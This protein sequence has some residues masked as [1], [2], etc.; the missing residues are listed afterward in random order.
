HRLSADPIER[1]DMPTLGVVDD[2]AQIFEIAFEYVERAEP[3]ERLDGVI[4]VANPAVA[5]IPVA[6]RSGMF[7]DRGGQRRDDRP[8][9]LML[10]QLE[11]DRCAD[12]RFL[13]FA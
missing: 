3:V 10:A 8:G 1:L 12:H 6:L 7:G 4:G 2:I 9:F 11:A 13:P 5:I